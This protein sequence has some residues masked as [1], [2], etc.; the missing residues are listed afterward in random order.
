VN[1][2]TN[3]RELAAVVEAKSSIMDADNIS[4]VMDMVRTS[5]TW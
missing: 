1:A 5:W 4:N 2:C 3:W